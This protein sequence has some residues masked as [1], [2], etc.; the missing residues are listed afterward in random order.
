MARKCF[1]ALVLVLFSA[2]F[3]NV[4]LSPIEAQEDNYSF[5]NKWGSEGVGFGSFAQPLSIAIESDD[6][7]YVTDTTSI[8]NQR[9]KFTNNGTFITSWGS[10]GLGDGQFITPGWITVDSDDNVYVGEF[11]ENYRIQKFDNNGTL[12]SK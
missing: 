6:S 3:C 12:I 9:K 1:A 7:V 8:S 2:S 11:G 4:T 5:A 10:A